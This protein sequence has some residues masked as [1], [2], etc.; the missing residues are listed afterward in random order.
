MIVIFILVSVCRIRNII[1]NVLAAATKPLRVFCCIGSLPFYDFK[2]KCGKTPQ[3]FTSTGNV[4]KQGNEINK[5]Y[6]KS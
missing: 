3:S 6:I 5:M 1:L 4:L 2:W